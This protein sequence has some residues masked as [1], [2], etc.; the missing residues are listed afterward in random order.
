[1]SAAMSRKTTYG[2]VA[3]LWQ[4]WLP[5]TAVDSLKKGKKKINE[6]KREEK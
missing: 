4:N 1:V 5:P 2:H 3:D 6:E